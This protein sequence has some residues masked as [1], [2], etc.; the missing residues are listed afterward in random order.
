MVEC[1]PGGEVSGFLHDEVRPDD[2]LELRGPDRRMVHLDR[3]SH[4]PRSSEAAPA[5]SRWSP[6]SATQPGWVSRTGCASSPWVV[7][8]AELPYS[9]ELLAAGAFVATT[10]ENLGS[11]VAAPPYPGGAGV[12][13]LR[14]RTCLRLRVGRV[15]VLRHPAAG[16]GRAS[17]PTSSGSSSSVRRADEEDGAGADRRTRDT[18]GGSGSLSR[19]RQRS[20][21]ALGGLTP[22]RACGRPRTCSGGGADRVA[23]TTSSSS[24][25]WT[26]K[27]RSPECC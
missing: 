3:R 7:R 8:L 18:G 6:C 17:A 4:R 26:T 2:V 9:G 24:S 22:W 1:L 16:R 11:R 25:G 14:H 23:P 13:R 19:Q 10:R 5:S 21:S 15:R 20:C 27:G 12:A